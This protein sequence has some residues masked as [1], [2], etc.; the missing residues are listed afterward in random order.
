MHK[1]FDKTK[2][3]LITSIVIA[4]YFLIMILLDLL[5]IE[6]AKVAAVR[7]LLLIPF[8]LILLSLPVMTSIALQKPKYKNSKT[9]IYTRLI[10][11]GT[12]I[13]I[14]LMIFS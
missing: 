5:E 3:L 2:I 4:I 6:T 13:A 8:F 12:L 7:S 9:L 10:S 14:I 1:A 11:I